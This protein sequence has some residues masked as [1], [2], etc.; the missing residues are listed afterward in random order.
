MGDE[1]RDVFNR[2]LWPG[3]VRELEHILE[4]AMNMLDGRK[5]LTIDHLPHYIKSKFQSKDGTL[6][7]F[8]KKGSSTLAQ[9]L[10][11][12]EKQVLWEAL[13]SHNGNITKAADSIG[14]AR[15]NLQYRM[16]KLGIEVV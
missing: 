4:S 9:V 5:V 15:Q 16:K 1:L 11:E 13:K 7:E 6:S 14:I 10:R 12:V 2:Y 8:Y 3:N